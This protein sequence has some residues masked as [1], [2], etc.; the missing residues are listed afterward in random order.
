MKSSNLWILTEERPKIEVLQKIFVRFA[1]DRGF[2]FFG[3]NIRILPLLDEHGSFRF[4][5]KVIGFDC[6]IVD[7][8]YIKCVSGSSSFVDFLIF[9]QDAEP[10]LADT[11]I[12]A[13]EETKTADSESRNTG[14][15]QRCSKF[16]YIKH[17]Y[18]NTPMIMLYSLQVDENR[19]PT[20]TNIFGMRLLMTFGVDVI[21]KANNEAF[22]PFSSIDEMI[23]FKK[24]MRLPPKGNIPILITQF[25]NKISVSG[26]LFKDGG[27]AHDPN[28]GGLSIIAAVLRQFGWSGEIEIT[29]HELQQQ[30]VGTDN[31]F[32]AIANMLGITLDGLHVPQVSMPS[33]Y[34]HYEIKGEKLATIFIHIVVENFTHSYSIFENHAGC[35]K[36]YFIT[37]SGE[38]IALQKYI[39]RAK[40]KA[41]DKSQIVA[42]PDLVL[43][44]IDRSSIVLIEG[45]KSIYKAQGIR[46]LDSYDAFET[47]YIQPHYTTFNVVK[48]LVLY[49]SNKTKVA[50]IKVGFL[51]NKRGQLVLG[52][53]APPLFKEAINNLLT[54]WRPNP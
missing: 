25:D 48:S 9:H 21:G 14:V 40:Y 54:Y 10:T 47:L 26:R 4:V 1:H 34:W 36:G 23:A 20:D 50:D 30:H 38:H 6:S 16:V 52:I 31:K 18:P 46:E 19:A 49:G 29:Q 15:M 2:G 27:L 39:D 24:Q 11:P 7:C 3:D 41:G 28:I 22:V 44:D 5:Y 53:S 33:E 12:Y 8:V 17:Y 32:I 45:K 35:E 37:P 42:I 13:I 51:L 43:V